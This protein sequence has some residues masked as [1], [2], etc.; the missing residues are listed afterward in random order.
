[1][2]DNFGIIALYVLAHYVKY[3][4]HGPSSFSWA[5][6]ASLPR[7]MLVMAFAYVHQAAHLF[8]FVHEV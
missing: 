3:L 4:M 2:V 1:M 5:V 7:Q 6:S 8:I